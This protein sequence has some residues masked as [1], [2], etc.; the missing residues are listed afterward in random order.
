MH[1]KQKNLLRNYVMRRTE[2]DVT[3]RSIQVSANQAA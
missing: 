3:R 1:N 2:N